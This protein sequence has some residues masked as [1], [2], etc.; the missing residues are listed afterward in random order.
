M[1]SNKIISIV[2][3]LALALSLAVGISA[4]AAEDD[5]SVEIIAQNIVYGERVQ[6]AYAVDVALEDAESV[7]V[8]YYL[9]GTPDNVIKAKLLSTSDPNNLYTVTDD[10]GT[11]SDTS[12]DV[13]TS[14]PVFV[15][16]GFHADDFTD[17]VYAT[18]Y[19]GETAPAAPEYKSYSVASYLYNMLYKN[20]YIN[21]ADGTE[22]GDRKN[23]YLSLIDYGTYA[24]K[25]LVNNVEGLEDEVL[26]GDYCY[27]WANDGIT[28]VNGGKY[29]LVKPGDTVT[30]ANTQGA[31]KYDLTPVS[32]DASECADSY[33]AEA[34]KVALV[35]ADLGTTPVVT[36][37]EDGQ[38][39]GTYVRNTDSSYADIDYENQDSSATTFSLAD[40]P[41]GATNKVLKVAKV[42]SAAVTYTVVSPSNEN[43]EGRCYTF[44]ARM[45]S[46]KVQYN[47]IRVEFV[48]ESSEGNVK[49]IGGLR[50]YQ[51]NGSQHVLYEYG[52]TS[53]YQNVTEFQSNLSSATIPM[54]S[55]FKLKFELYRAT[56]D[57]ADS[58]IKVWVDLEDGN[59]YQCIGD[60][61]TDNA[62][63]AY[64]FIGARI[65]HNANRAGID[66]FDDLSVTVTDKAYVAEPTE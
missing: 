19:T 17:V 60:K 11:P 16:T 38:L 30:L 39:T 63:S 22:K 29:A 56:S 64:T 18:A 55:W 7:T 12:D 3:T 10:N 62:Y 54:D 53:S 23:L 57:S 45:Y 25:V 47:D 24:Q 1:K 2:L 46:T 66:Y 35:S 4:F 32:G 34:G 40:D 14:Y 49:S 8:E 41:T 52:I 37:F 15:T 9:E 44:E 31:T 21:E 6:I 42:K 13:K 20:G 26:L 51:R 36:D 61:A 50:F 58:Y 48:A 43:Q 27:L 33:V 59:G 28:T 5:G 65:G